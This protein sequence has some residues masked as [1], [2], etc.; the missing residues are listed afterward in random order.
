MHA[1]S[2]LS[3]MPPLCPICCDR[4]L[5]NCR[6]CTCP[7]CCQSSCS[8]CL[9]THLLTTTDDPHC[10][11][12]RHALTTQN[13]Y[14]LL[15]RSF[16][17]GLHKKHRADVLY[18]RE[19]S[20]MPS[21]QP[22]VEQELQKRRN[23]DLLRAMKTER[24][25]MQF[26]IYELTRTIVSLERSVTPAIEER[27]TFVHRCGSADCRGFLSTQWK[28]GVCGHYTCPD[29]NA[30]RGPDKNGHHVCSENDV[31][32]M[33]RIRSECR[34]CPGCAQY[35]QRWFTCFVFRYRAQC[36]IVALTTHKYLKCHKCRMRPDVYPICTH[37]S[38][39]IRRAGTKDAR[40][41]GVSF[42]TRRSTTIRDSKSTKES[43]CIIHTCMNSCGRMVLS[44][45]I[46]MIFHAEGGPLHANL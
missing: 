17:L 30:D 15:S 2:K 39:S 35:I 33:R 20:M 18:Q 44:H 3:V 4:R 25:N 16:L 34:K 45:G 42:A 28:C 6:T 36:A 1:T 5:T 37:T 24:K 14:A 26:R 7:H 31:A 40:R 27:R 29:C 21:T 11:F 41:C 10:L 19:L 23:C 8:L 46:Q 43:R 22:F 9:Q 13:L 38:H 12:C 32:S